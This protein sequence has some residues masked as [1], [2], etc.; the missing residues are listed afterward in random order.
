MCSPRAKHLEAPL[1]DTVWCLINRVFKS[2]RE[3][4]GTGLTLS[5]WANNK[6][7]LSKSIDVCVC[8]P[9]SLLCL[10]L[11]CFCP[12]YVEYC[13][14]PSLPVS[15]SLSLSHSFPP[16]VS[17]VLSLSGLLLSDTISSF[18]LLL[19]YSKASIPEE[20]FR[21]LAEENGKTREKLREWG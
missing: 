8:L 12:L 1:G 13:S 10:Y 14:H 19:N 20:C 16:F 9:V 17:Q 11:I 5:L 2:K 18:N 3:L 4:R 6:G 21:S 7:C 15:F